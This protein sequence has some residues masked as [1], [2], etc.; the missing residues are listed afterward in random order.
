MDV[1]LCSSGKEGTGG[2]DLLVCTCM[3]SCTHDC[4]CGADG[5]FLSII[6]NY[7]HLSVCATCTD[8]AS[9]PIY[10]HVDELK[11]PQEIYNVVLTQE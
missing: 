11:P 7:T 9:L 10:I 3:C 1:G 6:T 8:I 2:K 5:S 4:G